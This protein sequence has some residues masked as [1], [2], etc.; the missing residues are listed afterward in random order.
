[1]KALKLFVSNSRPADCAWAA[2]VELVGATGRA[3]TALGWPADTE[4]ALEMVRRA[5][6]EGR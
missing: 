4:R 6:N 1:M 3:L 5:Y 2:A